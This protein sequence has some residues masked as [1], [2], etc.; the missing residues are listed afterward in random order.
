MSQSAVAVALALG[1]NL[2]DRE[3][4]LAAA[5]RQ[6]ERRGVVA[7]LRQSGVVETEAEGPPQPAYL[8]QV[9]TGK[10]KLAPLELLSALKRIEVDLGRSPAPR[11]HARLIDID[12][13]DYDQRRIELP[14]LIIPHA[15]IAHREFVLRPWSEIDATCLVP[16]LGRSVGELF[17]ALNRERP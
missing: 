4:K 14:G 6:L 9:I 3:A 13:L 1:S 15:E 8:N 10:T 17:E 5:R 7:I 11:R 12:I 16:G 2:G